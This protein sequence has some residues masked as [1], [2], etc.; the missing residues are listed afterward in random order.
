MVKVHSIRESR[1]P[2]PMVTWVSVTD[3]DGRVRLEMRWSV[4]NEHRSA[5]A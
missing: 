3:A 5:V 1:Q 4:R 2:G